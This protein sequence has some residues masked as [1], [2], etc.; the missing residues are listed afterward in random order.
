MGPVTITTVLDRPDLVPIVARWL[1]QE[2]GRH[3]GRTPEMSERRLRS[4]DATTGPE[5]TWILLDGGIPAATASLVHDDLDTRP[6]LTP[7]LASVFVDPPMRGRGHA[8]RLVRVVEDAARAG[9]NHT[10]W[11]HS[12]HAAGLYAGLG[13]IAVGAEVDHGHVVTLMRRDLA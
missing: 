1:W 5:Q 13:W 2:W 6:E 11:L 8:A 12:Q 9:G 3:K 7:W 10:L 4:R